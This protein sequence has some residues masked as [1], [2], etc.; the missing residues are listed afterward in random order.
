VASLAVAEAVL[1]A[2]SNRHD[3]PRTGAALNKDAGVEPR[4]VLVAGAPGAGKST[5]AKMIAADLRMALLSKDTVKEAL[6][7]AVA[8]ESVDRNRDLGRAA[9]AVLYALVRDQ[10]DVGESVVVDH[11][12]HQN[13]AGEVAPLVERSDAVLVHCRAP[14]DVLA[15]RVADRQQRGD[16]HAVH[17]DDERMPFRS[18]TYGVMEL[19]V[20]TLFVD[21]EDGYHPDYPTIL[22]FV[23]TRR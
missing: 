21:T 3:Q 14:D 23:E 18:D 10:L 9:V 15:Q 19:E 8:V 5:L 22:N 13:L 4:L 17:F 20:P 2:R 7:D 12:F 1:P 16:R 11:A 6:G